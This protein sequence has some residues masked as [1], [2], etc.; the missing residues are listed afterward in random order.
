MNKF[1]KS[2]SFFLIIALLFSCKTDPNRN[3]TDGNAEIN[4]RLKRDPA[5]L[6]PMTYPSSFSREIYQYLMVPL[7]DF[8]PESL[9]LIPILIKSIPTAVPITEGKF[10]G[11][12][13]YTLEFLEEAKWDNGTPITAQDF[14][15]TIK[16]IKNEQI[17][18]RSWRGY[19]KDL[20][21]VIIDPEN[22]KKFEV[23]FN[24]PYMLALEAIVTANLFPKHIYDPT[25][26]TDVLD[27]NGTVIQEGEMLD[28]TFV[29]NFNGV[30]HSREIVEGAGPYKLTA[31]ETDQF[32]T[33]E[34]KENYW[35]SNSS[36]PFL[37]AKPKK[38]NFK[39]VPEELS[40]L[41][42][43]ESGELNVVTGI[44]SANFKD[45][46]SNVEESKKYNFLSPQLISYY[47]LLVNNEDKILADPKV[48]EA[49]AYLTNV[50]QM[51]SNFENGNATPQVGH[52]HAT[53]SY[54]N[55]ALK[56]IGYDIEKAKSI[57]VEAGWTDS[58]SDGVLDKKING[59]K[60]DLSLDV[61]VSKAELGRKVSLMLQ[62]DAKKIG[63]VIKLVTKSG[64]EIRKDTKSGNYQLNTAAVRQDANADDP[65]ARWHSKGESNYTNYKNE[66]VDALIDK[67]RSIT[68]APGREG[69]YKEIQEKMYEDVPC[70][71]LYS[72]RERIIVSKNINATAT[73]KRPGYLANTFSSS[74]VLSEN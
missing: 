52:F 31:W 36:N 43:L 39:I 5:K 51:I 55:N 14:I 66:E 26:A 23:V 6:N 28:S 33:I 71:F 69:I 68:N 13:K 12:E 38:M 1:S 24:K 8:D 32:L 49:I 40:A 37:Q 9:Q 59:K 53:K 21:D 65:Y 7:A 10:K 57:L 63:V 42:L 41:T 64:S 56:P 4:I 73:P 22:E 74:M 50:D 34:R 18:S 30:V 25:N 35:A 27:I 58:D 67:L 3:H 60:E 47:Y 70:I 17:D 54:Y 19:F 2:L 11:G 61:L 45:L 15:F 72:P 16:S 46:K 44:S 48:R 62:S 20:V 29:K